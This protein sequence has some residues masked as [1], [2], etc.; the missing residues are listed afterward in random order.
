MLFY[1]LIVTVE[2][3]HQVISEGLTS[4][5]TIRCGF[6]GNQTGYTKGDPNNTVSTE[7]QKGVQRFS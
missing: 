3:V 2:A 4:Q 7:Q 5:T 6:V 1:Q